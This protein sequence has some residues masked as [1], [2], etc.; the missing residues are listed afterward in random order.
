MRKILFVLLLSVSNHVLGQHYFTMEELHNIFLLRGRNQIIESISSF[1]FKEAGDLEKRKLFA[2]TSDKVAVFIGNDSSSRVGL[3]FD[4]TEIQ[5]LYFVDSTV[6]V[7]QLLN[8]LGNLG[9]TLAKQQG[10]SFKSFTRRK[11]DYFIMF[12][13]MDDNGSISMIAIIPKGKPFKSAYTGK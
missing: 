2:E 11:T 3:L 10:D 6:I 13:W 12:D 1:G 7:K 9:F 8:D 4:R 5:S